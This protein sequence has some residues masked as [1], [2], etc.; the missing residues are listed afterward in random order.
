MPECL[1]IAAKPP[2]PCSRLAGCRGGSSKQAEGLL[3]GQHC[4]TATPA[5]DP[6]DYGRLDEC[7]KEETGGRRPGGCWLENPSCTNLCKSCHRL[8]PLPVAYVQSVTSCECPVAVEEA[9]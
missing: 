5:G 4:L 9:A 7:Q 8:A 3:P 6:A 1:S 2:I